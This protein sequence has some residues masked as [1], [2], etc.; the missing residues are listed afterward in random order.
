L[1]GPQ[2]DPWPEDHIV[3]G[4]DQ[5]G[6]YYSVLR[7]DKHKANF[8]VVWFYD[9]D[10]ATQEEYQSSIANFLNHVVLNFSPPVFEVGDWQVIAMQCVGPIKFGMPRADV[11]ALLN[12]PFTEF[13]KGPDATEPTD[14]FN[15]LSLHVFY[16]DG[17]VEAVEFWETHNIK[18][19]GHRLGNETFADMVNSLYDPLIPNVMTSTSLQSYS[20]GVE[21]GIPS[22]EDSDKIGAI[23]HV[24]V[25][26]KGYFE[27]A[28]AMVA[29]ILGK[30]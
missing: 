23:Q 5:C 28:D 11:R 10:T 3:I 20:F 12:Q 27:R 7:P 15:T 26:E 29:A 18:I 6:N 1:E 16:R 24:I 4:E 21:F 9:H 22:A 25:V 19:G 30:T 14:A 8:D 13:N 2:G 17:G